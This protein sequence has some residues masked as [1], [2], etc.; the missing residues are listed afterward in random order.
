M[1]YIEVFFIVLLA[2]LSCGFFFIGELFLGLMLVSYIV[3][4]LIVKV[5]VLED[6]WEQTEKPLWGH[7]WT[8]KYH[9]GLAEQPMLET[10]SIYKTVARQSG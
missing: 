8:K 1:K 3:I 2:L 9:S 5:F 4:R 6:L 10:E 7:I